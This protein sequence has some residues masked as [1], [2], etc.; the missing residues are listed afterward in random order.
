MPEGSFDNIIWDAAIEHF[1]EEEIATVMSGIKTR[2]KPGGRLSGHTIV[3]RGD[4]SK[5]L[6]QHEREFTSM[7]DLASFLTPHFANVRVFETIHPARH[8]LYFYASNGP[9]PFDADWQH[10]LRS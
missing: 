8:N 10:G 9:V 7:A 3:E 1:N 4:G 2:L 5:H 6:E